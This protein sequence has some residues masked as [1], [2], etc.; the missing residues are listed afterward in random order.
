MCGHGYCPK[1]DRIEREVVDRHR[2]SSVHAKRFP[3]SGASQ[4]LGSG[5]DADNLSW[6]HANEP[7]ASGNCEVIRPAPWHTV[8]TA[9]S[10]HA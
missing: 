3:V 9:P 1:G 6:H 5:D 4:L 10:E 2:K 8:M 7:G